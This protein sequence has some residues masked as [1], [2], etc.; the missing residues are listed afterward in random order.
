MA[1]NRKNGGHNRKDGRPRVAASQPIARD[2]R[3]ARFTSYEAK[4]TRREVTHQAIAEAAYFLWLREG[5]DPTGNWLKAER[6]LRH[7]S[8]SR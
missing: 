5:G 2:T 7:G 8:G 1:S 3:S 6:L 4:P